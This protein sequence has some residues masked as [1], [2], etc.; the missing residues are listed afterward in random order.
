MK[1][2]AV[3]LIQNFEG[4]TGFEGA[5]PA[6]S[7]IIVSGER[8]NYCTTYA[9]VCMGFLYIPFGGVKQI[10]PRGGGSSDVVQRA[11]VLG[12][13]DIVTHR[14]GPHPYLYYKQPYPGN[15]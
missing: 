14:G 8:I 1:Q 12:I 15:S 7:L 9:W 10:T 13:S 11:F 2:G 5:Q 6:V 4:E 3:Q